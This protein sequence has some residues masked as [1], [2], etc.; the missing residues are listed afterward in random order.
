LGYT[1]LLPHNDADGVDDILWN[2][3]DLRATWTGIEGLSLS[4]HNNIS[5]AKGADKDWYGMLP[6]SDSSFFTLYNAIGATITL[7]DRF[8]V[9]AQIG[10]I[11]SSTDLGS[12]GKTEQDTFWVEPKF[13]AKVGEHAEFNAGLR[14]DVENTTVSGGDDESV[15]TFSI[16]VGI[17]INF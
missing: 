13:I 2:G 11:F 8:S 9:N 15:T 16:P 1:G 10:N 6:G 14:L 12:A 17:K 3:I 4:T 5:F 7:S